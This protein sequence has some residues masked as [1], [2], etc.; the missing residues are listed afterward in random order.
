MDRIA[1][2]KED[3][4]TDVYDRH[5]YAEEDQKIMESLARHILS[6]AEGG[7]RGNVVELPRTAAR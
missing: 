2:H 1:N 4:V 7:N 3:G 6:L 5:G